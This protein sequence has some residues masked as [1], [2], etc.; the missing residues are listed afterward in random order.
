MAWQGG[1]AGPDAAKN[2]F[3]D[4]DLGAEALDGQFHACGLVAQALRLE[5]RF[6]ADLVQLETIWQETADH[7]IEYTAQIGHRTCS[8]RCS[9]AET[10]ASVGGNSRSDENEKPTGERKKRTGAQYHRAS[11]KAARRHL[12]RLRKTEFVIYAHPAK[13]AAFPT[14]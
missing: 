1:L 11:L 2:S 8:I 5:G 10:K 14:A 7:R 4:A 3:A 12:P 9:V 13:S 6:E